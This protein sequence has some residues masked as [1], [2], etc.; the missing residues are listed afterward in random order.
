MKPKKRNSFPLILIVLTFLWPTLISTGVSSV[1]A[2]YAQDISQPDIF[3]ASQAQSSP[4]GRITD[5]LVVLYTFEEGDG[6]VIKDVSGVSPAIDLSINNP[7]AV[8][9]LEGGLVI[10]SNTVIASTEAA[11]KIIE[12]SQASNEITIEAWIKPANTTQDGPARIVALSKSSTERNFALAQGLWANHPPNLYD[13]RLRTTNR[14]RGVPSVSSPAG[15]LEAKLTHVVYTR[16]KSGLVKIY[17]NGQEVTS[18]NITGDF[19]SWNKEYRLVLGNEITEDR[20]WLGEYRLVSIY[21]RALKPKDVNQNYLAGPDKT[22]TPTTDPTTTPPSS[23]TIK[24]IIDAPDSLTVNKTVNVGIKARNIGTDGI[25]GAQ[26]EIKFDPALVSADNL[27][28]HPDLEFILRSNVDNNSGI[29][30]VVASR[31]GQVAGLT[32][33]TTLL[34]FDLVAGNTNGDVTLEFTE[35]KLSDSKA[36]GLKVSAQ[37]KTISITDGTQPTP[38]PT[39]EPTPLPTDEPTSTPTKDP[40]PQPTVE[41]TPNPTSEPDS[42]NVFGQVIL[43]GRA[44]DNW[45]GASLKVAEI[46]S[47]TDSDGNF[48]LFDVPTETKSSVTANAPGFLSTV[49]VNPTIFTPETKLKTPTLLSG[50]VTDDDNVDIADATAVGLAFGQTGTGISADINLD[51]VMDIFDLVLVS[52]NFNQTG[53]QIWACQ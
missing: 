46:D 48:T 25:Y 30:T 43:A 14:P 29:I 26:L 33:D 10:K 12:T 32:D 6:T 3:S 36:M 22:D 35:K 16:T 20:P 38:E 1:Q 47:T 5:G 17:I 45:A 21:S 40:T 34:T 23:D 42:A 9:W 49:C 7:Q 51:E 39:D 24:L 15:S 18:E 27:Q 31:Q 28:I 11:T 4:T 19:S 2:Q 50:D 52:R 37:N 53:P 41:P 8:E 13:I 44:N